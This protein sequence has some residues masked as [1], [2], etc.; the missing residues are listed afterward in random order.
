[1]LAPTVLVSTT[2]VDLL[3]VR[4]RELGVAPVVEGPD[5]TVRLDGGVAVLCLDGA[6]RM[7]AIG[8]HTYRALAAAVT[9][10]ENDG[11]TRAVV[12]HGACRAFSAGADINMLSKESNE[13]RNH[14]AQWNSEGFREMLKLRRTEP[15]NIDVR[16]FFPDVTQQIDIPLERQFRM[17]PALH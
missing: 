5:V 2:P 9:A 17:M 6:E 11:Q 7:N 4:L 14:F 10:A 13:F 15:V 8:S 1:M 3:L 12:V 16:I